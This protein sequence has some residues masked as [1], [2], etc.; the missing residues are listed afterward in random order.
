[1][2]YLKE[3]FLL[4]EST[5]E[6]IIMDGDKRR[7]Y[8]S[9]YPFRLFPP[10]QFVRI[11][12]ATTTI[13][14][15]GNGSGKTTL[16]NVISDKLNSQRK[17]S[18]DKRNYFRMFVEACDFETNLQNPDEI[19]TITSDD[20]FDYL[21]EIRAINGNINRHKDTLSRTYQEAK[22]AEVDASLSNYERLSLINE[23]RKKTESKFIRERLVSNNIIE[24][25]NGES[26]LMFWE[27]E[28]KENGLYLLDEPENS[29]SAA[30]QLK[31]KQFIEES[32]RFYNCQFIISTHS[33]FLLALAD[34]RIYDLDAIPVDVKKWSELSSVRM[35]YDFFK[36]KEKEF[37]K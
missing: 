23:A 19:K 28:I 4:P 35:Y 21:L 25:S 1:M 22:Y 15:G 20:V 32:V 17:A 12:F 24:Q 36:N 33:P 30:N 3:F 2:E 14:Y 8:N 34:A 29:L 13:F 10:K 18:L 16:L 9:I 26:A 31:L 7:I 27:R 6:N 5:E 37:T 11:K